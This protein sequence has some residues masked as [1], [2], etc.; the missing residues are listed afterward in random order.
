MPQIES[1]SSWNSSKI[2][3]QS[4][5]NFDAVNK[6]QKLNPK[7]PSS[8]YM[9][10]KSEMMRELIANS[11]NETNENSL[12]PELNNEDLPNIQHRT[13]I[14]QRIKRFF[15]RKSPSI[16]NRAISVENF[17]QF[18]ISETSPSNIRRFDSKHSIQENHGIYQDPDS[19]PVSTV[20]LSREQVK[21]VI[22]KTVKD[23]LAEERITIANP[24]AQLNLPPLKNARMWEH[25]KKTGPDL[26]T[27]QATQV[28]APSGNS[29]VTIAPIQS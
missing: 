3:K 9:L 27:G 14:T 19:V 5:H 6:H 4:L 13:S 2:E 26:S 1:L 11:I 28:S 23:E 10:S 21:P 29:L 25:K 17:A 8:S 16:L 20:S 18:S 12:N 15:Q 22:F 7:L 24:K